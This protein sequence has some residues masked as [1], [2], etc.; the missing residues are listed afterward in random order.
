MMEKI[1]PEILS[2][3][4][5]FDKMRFAIAYGRGCSLY[6]REKLRHACRRCKF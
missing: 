6:G 2:P 1:K 3:A 4:G 5:D